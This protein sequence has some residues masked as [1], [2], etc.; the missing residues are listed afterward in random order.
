M[1]AGN[2]TRSNFFKNK[3]RP[4]E[5]LENRKGGGKQYGDLLGDDSNDSDIGGND[6]EGDSGELQQGMDDDSEPDNDF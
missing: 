1:M 5:G 2:R 6:Y 4:G 3:V